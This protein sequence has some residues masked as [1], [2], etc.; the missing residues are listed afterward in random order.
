[1]DGRSLPGRYDQLLFSLTLFNRTVRYQRRAKTSPDRGICKWKLTL[2]WQDLS[3]DTRVSF[4]KP[5]QLENTMVNSSVITWS[6][7]FETASSASR[8][9][10]CV[11]FS[12]RDTC[13]LE[14]NE[15]QY[16]AQDVRNEMRWG[17]CTPWAASV[18]W[19]IARKSFIIFV[20][21]RSFVHLT[22]TRQDG[23]EKGR[24]G[25]GESIEAHSTMGINTRRSEATW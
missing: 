18:C 15:D 8:T 7:K 13:A 25:H 19:F 16:A 12:S 20:A 6:H 5:V 21:S 11:R 14:G 9:Y 4:P 3:K 23:N 1:M 24:S 22:S 10:R 2:W 17:T